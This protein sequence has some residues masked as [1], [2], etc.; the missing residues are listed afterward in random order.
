MLI[1]RRTRINIRSRL[2]KIFPKKSNIAYRIAIVILLILYVLIFEYLMVLEGQPNNANIVTAIYFASSTIFTVGYGDIVFRSLAGRIFSVIVQ[3]VGIILISG[4]LIN[5]VITPWMDRVVKFRLPRKVSSGVKDH[6]IIC[7]YN[8]LVET[9]IDELAE[10]E[11]MFLIVDDEEE[12]IRELSYKDI[13]CIFGVSSDK[14]TLI[15]AGI[16]KARLLIANK[17]DETNANIVLTAREFDHITIIAIV[18]DRSNSKYLKYAGA[19]TVVSPKSM[20]GQFIGNKA[21][22]RL[23][24]RVTGATE[25]FE[26][27]NIVEFPVYLKSPLIGKTI[28]E[29]SNQQHLANTKIVGIWKSGTLSFDPKEE[30]I[31]RENSVLLAIGTPEGL[32]KLKKFTH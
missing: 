28:K 21:M 5:Y 1:P 30:D 20:F 14:Q 13:P 8:Q 31:I 2:R 17:S 26:G 15:N 6:I 12:L 11:L 9:L 25:I 3:F 10:Q 24:S 23:V 22:D 7:G 19:D 4:F 32:A 18:E 29:V 16:E 27:V